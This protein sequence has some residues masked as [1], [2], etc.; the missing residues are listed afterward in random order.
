[1][2][3]SSRFLDKQ[4]VAGALLDQGVYALTWTDLALSHGAKDAD[5]KIVSANSMPIKKGE[6][7]A[8]DIN[9]VILTKL[10][11]GTQS[12]VGIVTTSMTLVGSNKPDFYQRFQSKKYGP[13]VRIEGEYASIAVPFPPIR[14]QEFQV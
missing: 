5:I 7:E 4:A 13:C 9:T 11:K 3:M 10:E 6:T 14:P 1:M 8:D 2:P 12:A